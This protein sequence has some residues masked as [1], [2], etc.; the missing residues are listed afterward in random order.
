MGEKYYGISPYAYCAGNPISIIDIEGYTIRLVNNRSNA[1]DYLAQ[2]LATSLGREFVSKVI[3]SS[4]NYYFI[5]L[6]FTTEFYPSL[7][8]IFYLQ[9]KYSTRIDGGIITP[10]ISF[11]HELMHAYE[12]ATIGIKNR[13]YAEWQAV[14]FANYIR[15]AYSLSPQRV[16]YTGVPDGN[17]HMYQSPDSK[18]MISDF[19]YVGS[20]ADNTLHGYSY[21]KT[22]QVATKKRLFLPVEFDSIVKKSI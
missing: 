7:G 9:N 14:S 1:M 4:D 13:S 12:D 22:T 15:E 21:T 20:S 16:H 10:M 8:F 2:I 6:P 3:D 18:E 19:S 17:F 5:G 11:A